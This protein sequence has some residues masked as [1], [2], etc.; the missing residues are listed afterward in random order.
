MEDYTK[1]YTDLFINKEG[2]CVS[3]QDKEYTIEGMF[4]PSVFFGVTFFGNC[5]ESKK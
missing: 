1:E 5:L 3:Q 4:E 2:L